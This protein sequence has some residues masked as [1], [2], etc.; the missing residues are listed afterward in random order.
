VYSSDPASMEVALLFEFLEEGKEA[1]LWEEAGKGSLGAGKEEKESFGVE[2]LRVALWEEEGKEEATGSE[3][4]LSESLYWT[5]AAFIWDESARPVLSL[6]PFLFRTMSGIGTGVSFYFYFL[7]LFSIV[8]FLFSFHI[9]TLF[10]HFILTILRLIQVSSL[11]LL[12]VSSCSS[13]F[14]I[15]LPCLSFVLLSFHLAIVLTTYC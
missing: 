13:S 1:D 10:P 5:R 7:F 12:C 11:C 9:S 2:S 15:S 6:A 14:F 8:L 3:S 4:L